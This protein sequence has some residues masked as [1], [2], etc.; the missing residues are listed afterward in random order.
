MSDNKKINKKYI[1]AII[2]TILLILSFIFSL[3]K[4]YVFT[5]EI[6]VV[7]NSKT[8]NLI[9]PD[10]AEITE[11]SYTDDNISIE[12]TSDRKFESTIHVAD[13]KLKDVK[14]FKSAFAKNTYGRNVTQKVSEIAENN[15]AIFAINADYYGVKEDGFVLRNGIWYRNIKNKYNDDLIIGE[16]GSFKIINENQIDVNEIKN[17]WQ[18]FSFGPWI[19]KDNKIIQDSEIITTNIN[20]KT[21]AP[22]TGIGII[23]NLHYI[24]IVVD[25]RTENEKGITLNEFGEIFKEYNVKCAYNLD[26]GGSSI[27]WFN[28][29]ILNKPSDGKEREVSD[30]A[31]IGY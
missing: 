27:M 25:G 9:K 26:G 11:N 17:A 30:I 18:I 2:Y 20:V 6:S 29:K 28:G 3:L 23:D 10:N 22:R 19:I 16:D 13:I 7:D 12:I 8:I 14:L 24:A 21:K 15:S 4:V 31:Y 5:K 1:F